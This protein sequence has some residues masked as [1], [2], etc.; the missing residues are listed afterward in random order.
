MLRDGAIDAAAYELCLFA[1]LR[2]RLRAGDVWV[3]GSRQYRAV[4]DQLV[5]KIPSDL[6]PHVAPLSWQH[7]NLTGDYIWTEPPRLD[8][9]GF[10]PLLAS[11]ELMAA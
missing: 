2:D 9:D 11:V 6:L 3:V 4:E 1:E 10:R 8:G 5:P 7:I